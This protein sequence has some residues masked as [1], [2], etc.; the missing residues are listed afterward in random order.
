MAATPANVADS[1][2]LPIAVARGGRPGRGVT[3]LIASRRA[4][5]RARAQGRGI[6]GSTIAA[7]ARLSAKSMDLGID[8]DFGIQLKS[9]TLSRDKRELA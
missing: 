2:V 9:P 4:V 1:T 3:R 7:T 6:T 8:S 5:I